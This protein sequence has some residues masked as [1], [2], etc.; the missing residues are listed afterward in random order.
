MSPAQLQVLRFCVFY[1]VTLSFGTGPLGAWLYDLGSYN[2]VFSVS[3]GIMVAC[4][5]L[6]FLRLWSFN[7][8]IKGKELTVVD[9]IHPRHVIESLKVTFK[10]RPGHRRTYLIVM[11]FTMLMNM[12]PFI[13]EGAFQFPYVKRLF[14]WG[15]ADYS[16]YLTTCTL[17]SSVAMLVCFPIF[18]RLRTTDNTV[19][20]ISCLSQIAAGV[21]RGFAT[22]VWHFYA[23]AVVDMGTALV[24][25]PI[26]AQ[27][28]HCVE[29]HE[30]GK[31]FAM[32]ASVESAVPIIGTQIY[33]SL[34]SATKL[35]EYPGPGSC[36]FA[37][38]GFILLGMLLTMGNAFSMGWRH[39]GEEDPKKQANGRH[40]DD[41]GPKEENVAV[42]TS[43]KYKAGVW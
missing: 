32:L 3:T 28:S 29:P 19:I 10:S 30:L 36:Y 42:G 22:E 23:S 27:L 5:L 41:R 16:W 37:T 4:W 24:S 17:I 25:P 35:L 31:V 39:L 33:T 13:G 9:M 14:S 8:L 1:T 20:I 26:R 2:L 12:M 34:Y 18:H 7:E 15:V 43:V 11:M 40:P 38:C 21:I 6:L